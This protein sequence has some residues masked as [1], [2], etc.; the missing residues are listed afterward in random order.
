MLCGIVV[1]LNYGVTYLGVSTE[2]PVL[3]LCQDKLD[4]VTDPAKIHG[5]R[6]QAIAMNI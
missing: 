3:E 2:K 1:I 6:L 4:Y 5:S